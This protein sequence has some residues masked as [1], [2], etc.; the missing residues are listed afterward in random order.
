MLLLIKNFKSSLNKLSLTSISIILM[1]I[2]GFSFVIMHS[3]A[4]YLSSEIHIFE[5]TFLRC[6]LVIFVLSPLIFK[7]GLKTFVT[8]QPK[9]QF[10]RIITNSIA[11]ICFFYG[12]TLTTLSQVTALNLTVPIF[13]TMLAIF[14]LNE[15]IKLRRFLALLVGFLGT[16][17]VLRPDISIDV[18]GFFILLSSLIWSISLI[19]IKKLTRTDSAVTISLYAGVGMVPATFIV[20]YPYLVIPNIKQTLIII[21]IAVTGTIAQTL[22]NSAFKRGKLSILLPFDFLK[23]VW[24]ILIGYTL[25]LESTPYTLWLGGLLIVG[26]SSYIAWREKK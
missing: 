23:L 9:I 12:L 13:G 15:K 7:Q 25:F 22:L 8:K 2:S 21:F 5:I 19:F 20:A 11:M 17:I 10:Y 14:F 1:I 26:S 24:A 6:L 18:G 16:I 4:K 3:A